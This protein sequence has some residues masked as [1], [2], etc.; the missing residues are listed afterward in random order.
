[1]VC[2]KRNTK[3]NIKLQNQNDINRCVIDI[4]GDIFLSIFR[5]GGH[6]SYYNT[7]TATSQ[8]EQEDQELI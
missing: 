2:M 4:R 8:H 3:N 1:M 6:K 5:F 7:I